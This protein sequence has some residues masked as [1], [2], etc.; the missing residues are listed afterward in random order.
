V[1]R[2]GFQISYDAFFTQMIL[3]GLATSS[4]NGISLEERA[5]GGTSRGWPNFSARLPEAAW[6]PGPADGQLGPLEKDFRSSYTERW[7]FGFQREL[8][9]KVMI[10]GSYVG[11]QS[12]KLA[13]FADVNPRR[14]DGNRD[15]REFGQRD[16]R[17]SQGNSSYHSMQWRLDRR[18]S[19]GFHL[20][21]SYT[22]SRSLDS[23]SEGIGTL[24]TQDSMGNRLSI[25][26]ADGGLRLDRG[27]SIYDR[28]HRFTVLHLW[29]V[30]GP[31]RGFWKHV[32]GGWSVT[33][34]ASFQSGAPFTV[35]NGSG[36]A[37][38]NNDGLINDRPDIGNPRAPLNSRAVLMAA[39]PTGYVNPDTNTCVSP[40][41]VHWVQGTG[42]PNGSTVGR[43]TL[44]AGAINN[45][46]LALFKSFRFAETKRLEF[47]W[48]AFNALNHPQFTQIPEKMVV[49]TPGPQAG[50][51][52]RFLNRD[53]TDSGIR[54]MWLQLKLVF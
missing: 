40:G 3:L 22:W 7:S 1:W 49:G 36:I 38:R 41:D 52:S 21:A 28:T 17:T 43:N 2:G 9:N 44:L 51:P 10:D 29:E 8:S 37:D 24:G 12:H 46:D 35:W 47:R 33:G 39:C 23:T 30:P 5:P 19:R 42:L 13:T 32:L 4:P 48:E 18:F 26:A 20:T 11:S 16:I 14:L 27:P 31:V 50:S 34:I 6:V 45:F 53:F 15:H 25:P 54:S